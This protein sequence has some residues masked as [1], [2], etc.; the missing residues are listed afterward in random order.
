M[1]PMTSDTIGVPKPASVRRSSLAS[2]IVRQALRSTGFVL[3][4][5]LAALDYVR[6]ACFCRHLVPPR[7]RSLWQQR[8]ARGFSRIVGLRVHHHGTPPA[9]GMIVSNHLSYLDILAYGAL[10][11]C[12]FVAKKEV[13]SWPALGLLARM[14]GTIFV[15]RT[16]R[17]KVG[18]ANLRITEALQAG[19]IVIL[20]AEGTSSDGRTVLPFRSALLEPAA[21]SHCTVVPAAIRYHLEDGSVPD[22][23]CYWRDMTL[24]PHLLNLF[25]K[26][27]VRA[28]VA[29]GTGET[30]SLNASRKA[31]T[32][33]LRARVSEL[34]S[35]L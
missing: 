8:W 9:A 23:V 34:H 31:I 25:S 24:L 35:S 29:F 16:R 13:A 1:S 11:P 14:A 5:G 26:D 27:S 3:M 28:D 6:T 32:R 2:A 19:N 12:V 33:E 7:R 21:L 10:V 15:D 17:T 30:G 22:E 4:L 20:F 18:D